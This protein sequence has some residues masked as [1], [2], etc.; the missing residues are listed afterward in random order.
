MD[1]TRFPEWT[2]FN[3]LRLQL[4][5][6]QFSKADQAGLKILKQV[7]E[8]ANF[9]ER[10]FLEM[11]GVRQIAKAGNSFTSDLITSLHSRKSN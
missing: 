9:E 2:A 11:S 1:T 8:I 4:D 7:L 10:K 6:N 3:C 5:G